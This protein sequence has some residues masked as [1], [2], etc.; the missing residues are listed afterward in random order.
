MSTTDLDLI[1]KTIRTVH[2]W[3][4]QGVEFRDITPVLQNPETFRRLIDLFVERYRSCGIE[5]IVGIDARGFILGS[6]LAYALGVGFVPARKKGKLPA[7][8]VCEEYTLEY[9]N[10]AVELHADAVKPGERV[11]LVDDLIATGG[12]LLASSK[13]VEQL[14]GSIVEVVALIGLKDLGGMER[15][16]QSGLKVHTFL[17]Y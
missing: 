2:N 7:A 3:P 5:L 8:T 9:G 10:A 1:A 12:T 16:R 15:L 17:E 4:K 13:L 14:G 11:L 6:A